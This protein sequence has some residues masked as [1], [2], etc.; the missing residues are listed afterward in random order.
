MLKQSLVSKDFAKLQ[1]LLRHNRGQ[2]YFKLDIPGYG[3][4]RMGFLLV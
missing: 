2:A 3:S 4:G 1:E